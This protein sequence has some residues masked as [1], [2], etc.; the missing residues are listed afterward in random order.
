[1]KIPWS[2]RQERIYLTIVLDQSSSDLLIRRLLIVSN[3]IA[4]GEASKRAFES[5]APAR[6]TQPLCSGVPSSVYLVLPSTRFNTPFL[7][8]KVNLMPYIAYMPKR[9]DGIMTVRIPTDE[10]DVLQAIADHLDITLSDVVVRSVRDYIATNSSA[11]RK[12]VPKTTTKAT[13][14][15]TTVAKKA[16]SKSPAKPVVKIK[17]R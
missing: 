9:R 12:A 2:T 13:V 10:K 17:S 4:P 3:D 14:A 8:D 7:I 1:L 6:L 11:L 5:L 15:K 16:P